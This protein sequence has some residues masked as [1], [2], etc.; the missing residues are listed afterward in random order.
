MEVFHRKDYPFLWDISQNCHRRHF[1]LLKQESYP[2]EK[3][4]FAKLPL[5]FVPIGWFIRPASVFSL[6]F[7]QFFLHY[8]CCCWHRDCWVSVIGYSLNTIQPSLSL[9]H[10][11]AMAEREKDNDGPDRNV[12]MLVIKGWV[13]PRLKM[14]FL[15][16]IYDTVSDI[17]AMEVR[18]LK[19]F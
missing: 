15:H 16:L 18:Y 12:W 13:S 5:E 2:Y 8:G 10:H 6:S 1:F 9:N 14:T 19:W 3:S 11:N 17:G 4:L 7:L